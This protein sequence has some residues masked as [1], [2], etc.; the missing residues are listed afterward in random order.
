MLPNEVY[1]DK[2]HE[3]IFLRRDNRPMLSFSQNRVA[4]TKVFLSRANYVKAKIFVYPK[5]KT[6]FYLLLE[7]SKQI[8]LANLCLIL[9]IKTEVCFKMTNF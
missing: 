3:E 5:H 1:I 2:H 8:F 6:L 4:N 9:M 7:P